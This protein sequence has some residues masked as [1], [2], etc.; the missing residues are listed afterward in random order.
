LER[1]SERSAR[2]DKMGDNS[3]YWG[4]VIRERKEQKPQEMTKM[5]D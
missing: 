3:S 4:I 2:V 1:R 5:N